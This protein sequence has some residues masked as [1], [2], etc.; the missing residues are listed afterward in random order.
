MAKELLSRGFA[1][2][3]KLNEHLVLNEANGFDVAADL[4]SNI[5]LEKCGITLDQLK[6]KHKLDGQFLP[7]AGLVG[8]EQAKTRFKENPEL[9]EISMSVPMGA[10]Q[11]ASFIFTRGQATVVAMNTKIEN[12]EMKRVLSHLDCLFEDVNS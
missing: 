1:E 10:G 12:A 7:A 8:G 11:T 3:N 9:N 4:Y 5:V 6:K 2:E